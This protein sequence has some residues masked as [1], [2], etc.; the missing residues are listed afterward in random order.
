MRFALLCVIFVRAAPT[1][2]GQ[3]TFCGEIR[4]EVTQDPLPGVHIFADGALVATS[5]NEGRFCLQLSDTHG[6]VLFSLIGYRDVRLDSIK[7][8]EFLKVQLRQRPYDL[9]QIEVN[10]VRHLQQ[11]QLGVIQLPVSQIQFQ[12]KLLGESDP[13][14]ALVFY[15]GVSTGAE[16][17]SGLF[18][19]G[20]SPDQNLVLL[21]D[22]PLYNTEHLFGFLSTVNPG[23]TKAVNLYKGGIPS[24]YGGRASSVIDIV[25]RQGNQD[26]FVWGYTLGFLSNT[27]TVEGPFLKKRGNFVLSSRIANFSLVTAPMSILFNA[28]A[29][30][31]YSSYNLYDVNGKLTYD[32]T[33]KSKLTISLYT[34]Q[35]GIPE[36]YR[37]DNE[38][39]KRRTSYGHLNASLKYTKSTNQGFQ[40]TVLY[41]A[42]FNSVDELSIFEENS[43]GEDKE[44]VSFS[45]D[46]STLK[47][48]G[49][50]HQ[51]NWILN[52]HLK[53]NAGIDFG[54]FNIQPNSVQIKSEGVNVQRSQNTNRFLISMPYISSSY[55]RNRWSYQVGLRSSIFSSQAYSELSV[56]PRVSLSFQPSFNT[57]LDIA[58]TKLFQPLH[59]LTTTTN[60]LAR[61]QWIGAD[62][63]LPPTTSQNLSIDIGR[64]FMEGKWQFKL[65][66][67]YRTFE[68]LVDYR[69]GVQFRFNTADNY[70]NLIA[71]QGQGRARGLEFS[72]ETQFS[73]F[74]ATLSLTYSK[75]ERRF[76]GINKG[77]WFR[78]RFDRRLDVSLLTLHR[79]GK[80]LTL[81]TACSVATGFPLTLPAG[82]TQEL[83]WG[84]LPYFP[85]RF[86]AEAPLYWRFDAQVTR[87]YF[88][89]RG[90]R[91]F[92]SAGIYNVF[93]H[94]NPVKVEL[95]G[96]FSRIDTGEG[97][98][99]NSIK[100]IGSAYFRFVPNFSIG[101]IF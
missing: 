76:E 70:L 101:R 71:A 58:F 73:S 60:G 20:G 12:P 68:N 63:T 31:N 9:P 19:R 57:I 11:H 40:K 30:D 26:H 98:L 66:G 43:I 74:D 36:W 62:E 23:I 27:A 45:Q 34:G 75:S 59:L 42:I 47:E 94:F 86:N 17:S 46:K 35:D 4:E 92:W 85:E 52:R 64:T 33:S 93:M 95:D 29:L 56:E 72:L 32:I 77:I 3:H 38:I 99:S 22:V 82:Y 21:D 48:I 13:M 69:R 10:A 53:L 44:L 79:I 1:L 87:K 2:Q 97:R 49:L 61:Y 96:R 81:S 100:K 54:L 41:S 39:S 8:D 7:P 51:Q 83:F 78:N 89:K 84:I 90:R 16:G 24:K 5:S 80:T 37:E 6:A 55:V 18:V 50:K 15:P 91:A 28:G 65:G 67:F 25:S 14:K 88:T